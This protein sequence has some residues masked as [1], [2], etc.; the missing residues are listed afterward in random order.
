LALYDYYHQ[1]IRDYDQVIEAHRQG[2]ALPAVEPLASTRR[3]RRRKDNAASFDAR[4]R[5]HHVAGVDLT[6]VEGSEERPAL[7]V[8]SAIGTDMRRW[9][10]EKHFGSWLGLAPNPQKSGGKVQSSATP[11]G[12]NRAAQA[13]WVAAKNVQRSKRALGAC[14]RRIAARRGLA[15][16]PWSRLSHRRG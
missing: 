10:C 2:L 1:Q 14:C 16:G 6:A 13:L 12:V 9:P 8:C 15:S 7:V 5:L 4:Q 3:G 11:P